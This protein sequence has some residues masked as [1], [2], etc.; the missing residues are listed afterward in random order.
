M[1]DQMVDSQSP[2]VSDQLGGGLDSSFNPL[3]EL[4]QTAITESPVTDLSGESNQIGGDQD[5]GS[6]SLASAALELSNTTLEPE[7]CPDDTL[8]ENMAMDQTN[9]I[10][11]PDTSLTGS[12]NLLQLNDN[13]LTESL[14]STPLLASSDL[15]RPQTGQFNYGEALQKNFL[16]F[17]ANQSGELSP[18]NR[19]EWRSDSTLN[20]GKLQGVDLEGGYFDAGDHVKFGQPMAISIGMLALGG[21]EYKEAYQQSGQMDE[22][23]ETVKHGTDYF[24]KAH[25]TD[26]NGK[27][28]KLWVQVGEGGVA[29]DHGYWGSPESVESNTTRNAFFIDADHPGT[30]VAASTAATL[31]FSSALFRGVDDQYADEL[32]DNAKSLYEFAETNL[33]KYSD[34]VSQASP[35]Y[36][37]W[38]GYSDELA[39]GAAAIA[40]VTGDDTYLSKAEDYF[41]NDQGGLGDWSWAADDSSYAAAT[42]LAQISDDSYFKEQTSQWLDRWVSGEGEVD[43]TEGGFAHRADWG[44]VATTSAT[45]FLAELY[46][47]TV[48]HNQGYSDFAS[49][50]VDYILGDNPNNFSYMIGFGDNYAQSPHHRGSNPDPNSDPTSVQ[51]HTLFGAIVGGPTDANDN[52]YNDIRTDF[53]SNEVGTSY[54]APFAGAVIQQYD[55]FGGDPLSDAQLEALPEINLAG[56]E[57]A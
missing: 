7:M 25:E 16:F 34:S 36:T 40:K 55:N 5:N 47:D 2:L 30:D 3:A 49:N 56:S 22:L 32:L 20:D 50:Q 23:L 37:S 11:E 15:S 35:F 4:A 10:P 1:E 28:Q 57:L 24:L 21:I 31:A 39:Y 33:G 27:T 8:S 17:E 51:E 48:E 6:D 38:S 18:N 45:A 52:A 46:S 41:K 14:D 13:I 53:V 26:E 42:I 19:I 12:G 54:N 44:S 29:N 9:M 43:Y